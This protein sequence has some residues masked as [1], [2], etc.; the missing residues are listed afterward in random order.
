MARGQRSFK[1]ESNGET[2]LMIEREEAGKQE[3]EVPPLVESLE[4]EAL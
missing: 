2:V 1:E 4:R 3:R